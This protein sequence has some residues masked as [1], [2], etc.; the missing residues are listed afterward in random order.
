VWKIDSIIEQLH[1]LEKTLRDDHSLL[2]FDK[3]AKRI[4]ME[5]R[6]DT[7]KKVLPIF[8]AALRECVF[9]KHP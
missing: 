9:G 8:E 6:I 1:D 4:F 7:L 2:L 5:N 3:V